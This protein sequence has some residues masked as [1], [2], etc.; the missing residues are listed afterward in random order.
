MERKSYIEFRRY[1]PIEPSKLYYV[2]LFGAVI[3]AVIFSVF[4]VELIQILFNCDS[5]STWIDSLIFLLVFYLYI[6]YRTTRER[7]L[8]HDNGTL[9]IYQTYKHYTI[10]ISSI[11]QINFKKQF[12]IYYSDIIILRLETT[13]NKKIK[14]MLKETKEFLAELKK[15]N[16][17][18]IIPE[19]PEI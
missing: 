12:S 17:D 6:A 9:E 4:F 15:H 5:E 18:I 10:P 8:V 2:I 14:L 7:V 13:Q 11:E 16:P 3:F 1:T 19:L